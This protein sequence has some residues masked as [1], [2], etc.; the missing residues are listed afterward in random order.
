[1]LDPEA[2]VVPGAH[3][4]PP[5]RGGE[6]GPGSG[7]RAR[8][9]RVVGPLVSACGLA[10]L[11]QSLEQSTQVSARGFAG[12]VSPPPTWTEGGRG[13][14]CAGW[15]PGRQRGDPDRPKS[16]LTF[17]NACLLGLVHRGSIL[18][19][20]GLEGGGERGRN[21]PE[22]CVPCEVMLFRRGR[23]ACSLGFYSWPRPRCHL[24]MR[25]G[26][27]KPGNS[28]CPLQWICSAAGEGI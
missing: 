8:V 21:D 17:K 27:R 25:R 9:T 2:A 7:H 26:G 22:K 15:R 10:R 20:L 4:C 3:L 19:V 11:H 1:M 16:A 6:R 14:R 24:Q 13:A 5:G 23:S 18:W 28:D 12:P